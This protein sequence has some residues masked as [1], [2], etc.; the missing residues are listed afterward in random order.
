MTNDKHYHKIQPHVCT[1]NESDAEHNRKALEDI[2]R[3]YD[4]PIEIRGNVIE[5]CGEAAKIG[6]YDRSIEIRDNVIVDRK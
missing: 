6:Y 4:G 2:A 1:P 3:G 5:D